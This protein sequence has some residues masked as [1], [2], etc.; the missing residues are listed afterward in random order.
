MSL[1][2]GIPPNSPRLATKQWHFAP[3]AD[4]SPI[5][6][7]S[8]GVGAALA[9]T[10]GIGFVWDVTLDVSTLG[11]YPAIFSHAATKVPKARLEVVGDCFLHG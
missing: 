4:T 10:R 7:F 8:G 11:A 6:T 9:D 3:K 1:V 5:A 2:I